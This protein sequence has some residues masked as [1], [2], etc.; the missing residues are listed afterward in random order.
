MTVPPVEIMTFL[1]GSNYSMTF[2]R[3]RQ[4]LLL[5]RVVFHHPRCPFPSSSLFISITIDSLLL[6]LPQWNLPRKFVLF[7]TK[8]FA[9]GILNG[10]ATM[11]KVAQFICAKTASK[12]QL[13]VTQ[14][15]IKTYSL[16]SPAITV[17]VLRF[18]T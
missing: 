2:L 9:N 1:C 13:L 12:G 8:Y 17:L 11:K 10:W 18:S 14:L 16:I 3:G 7:Q 5:Q 6:P 4:W 15:D